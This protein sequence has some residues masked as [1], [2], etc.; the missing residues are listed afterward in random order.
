MKRGRELES[1]KICYL[2]SFASYF[3]KF[4]RLCSFLLVPNFVRLTKMFENKALKT[5]YKNVLSSS[6]KTCYFQFFCKY[7]GLE[8]NAMIWPFIKPSYLCL[9]TTICRLTPPF[10]HQ[11][12]VCSKPQFFAPTKSLPNI[13]WR[14]TQFIRKFGDK[15][16]LLC[17]YVLII[18]ACPRGS[19]KPLDF[20]CRVGFVHQPL[21]MLLFSL[22][23]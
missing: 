19:L 14:I 20:S 15:I 7:F 4:S 8:D 11:S 3:S 23:D 17:S 6:I 12:F 1:L 22:K 18:R 13:R 16:V 2:V 10:Q 5:I 9:G 21:L